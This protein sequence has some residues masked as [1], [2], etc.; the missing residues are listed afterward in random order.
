MSDK[1]KKHEIRRFYNEETPTMTVIKEN[2]DGTYLVLMKYSGG[3]SER[4]TI[5]AEYLKK[6]GNNG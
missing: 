3:L 1:E 4:K 6:W 2:P 5:T